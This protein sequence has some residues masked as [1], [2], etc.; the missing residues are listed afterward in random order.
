VLYIGCSNGKILELRASDGTLNKTRTVNNSGTVGDIALDLQS[1][2]NK[3]IA[4]STAGR[5]T[6]FAIPF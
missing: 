1:A 3:V 4:G 6:A 5:I 2:V